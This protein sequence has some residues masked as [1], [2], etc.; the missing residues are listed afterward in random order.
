MIAVTALVALVGT[1]WLPSSVDGAGMVEMG[2]S[3]GGRA[4][5]EAKGPR[6]SLLQGRAL[7]GIMAMRLR[8]G[9]V[10]HEEE[11]AVGRGIVVHVKV[12]A[13]NPTKPLPPKINLPM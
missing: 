12:H 1:M 5:V 3:K 2:F 11:W 4:M 6:M 9:G 8:G 13:M 7:L 10:L